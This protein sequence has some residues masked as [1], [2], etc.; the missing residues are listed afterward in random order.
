MTTDV[1]VSEIVPPS[2]PKEM[3]VAKSGA[4]VADAT[5]KVRRNAVPVIG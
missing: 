1:P 3:A 5:S 4:G 2:R